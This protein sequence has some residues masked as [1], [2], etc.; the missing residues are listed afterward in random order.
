MG[1]CVCANV[2]GWLY[3]LYCYSRGSVDMPC[4]ICFSVCLNCVV[5]EILFT[6]EITGGFVV[7]T[8]KFVSDPFVQS[9][10]AKVTKVYKQNCVCL[11]IYQTNMGRTE[12]YG[13]RTTRVFIILAPYASSWW[14]QAGEVAFRRQAWGWLPV[15]SCA[16][17]TQRSRG[18]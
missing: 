6:H 15:L 16:R 9:N 12:R 3:V 8:W 11:Y 18:L 14:R 17:A 1:L 10:E 7:K 13:R 4:V 5:T 2:V